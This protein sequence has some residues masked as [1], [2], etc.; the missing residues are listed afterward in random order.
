[1][2]DWT[3]GSPQCS[4][5]GLFGRAAGLRQAGM[6]TGLSV[7]PALLRHPWARA[8]RGLL[9]DLAFLPFPPPWKP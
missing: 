7:I 1:M 2:L 9:F 3:E 8:W 6:E 4:L 5:S